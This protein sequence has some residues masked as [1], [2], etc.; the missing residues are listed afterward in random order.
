MNRSVQVEG[1]SRMKKEDPFFPTLIQL[2]L[3]DLIG[4]T[5]SVINLPVGHSSQIPSDDDSSKLL[6]REDIST[7]FFPL[8]T[9]S[10]KIK[11]PSC[12]R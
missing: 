6:K 9:I 7:A 10:H 8:S 4:N 2:K 5:P 12:P 11:P 3:S 1:T